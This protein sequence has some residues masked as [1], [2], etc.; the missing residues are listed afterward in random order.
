MKEE[1]IHSKKI[2]VII[3]C[4]NEEKGIGF[5][6][7]EVIGVIESK[8][9]DAEIIVVDNNSTDGTAEVV[10]EFQKKFSNLVLV[11]EGRVGYGSAY[12]AGFAVARGKYILLADG[13]GT[14]DFSLLSDFV[15]RLEKGFGLVMGNRFASADI[16]KAMPW[17][18][19][20]IGN[21][22]LSFL[23]RVFF[24]VK[25]RDVHCGMRAISREAF[26]MIDLDTLGMEF[27]SEMVIKVAKRGL[28]ISEF[29]IPYRARFGDSKLRSFSDGWRH[30]R[31]ILLYSPLLL[32]LLPGVVLS[33][34]GV[35]GMIIFYF[36]H[37]NVLGINFYV[38]P[39][40]IFSVLVIL[41]YQL[42]T[43]S[44]FSK[45][46]AISH[47]GDRNDFIE[48][49]FKK[50]TIERAG[51]LGLVTVLVGLLIYALIFVN[52]WKSGFGSLNEVKNSI[53]ALTFLVI[54]VQTVFS[55][56]M[57]STLGIKAK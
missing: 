55:A 26:Q 9:L 2:S 30:L 52:W 7:E 12:L 16:K 17:L 24:G 44:A 37:P 45:I 41:G 13:D 39:M 51:I 40:F 20:R 27:A 18:H 35:I 46:Y 28:K 6:L 29:D 42:I 56:F 57:L 25:V 34:L 38:H 5:C 15:I 8:H 31:F 36:G 19:R 14:Y 33:A 4:L 21:P 23:V 53:L 48:S 43:F 49:L 54:G 3:P 22:F 47:L 10:T 50:I 11:K 1:G 32:F